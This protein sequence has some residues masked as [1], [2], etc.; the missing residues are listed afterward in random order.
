MRKLVLTN[1]VL[2]LALVAVAAAIM[3]ADPWL[4][5]EPIVRNVLVPLSIP[6]IYTLASEVSDRAL[7]RP[8][9]PL[10]NIFSSDGKEWDPAKLR[11]KAAVKP[12]PKPKLAPK[13]Q[14]EPKPTAEPSITGLL[15][16]P[17]VSA[18]LTPGGFVMEGGEVDGY[19]LR[20]IDGN[21]LAILSGPKG[22][23]ALQAKPRGSP[24]IIEQIRRAIQPI[25]P[26]QR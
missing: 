21:G 10:R 1:R 14:A 5:P 16:L 23:I 15:R 8:T 7:P 6:P 17:N 20:S 18:A 26:P 13:E 2:W 12:K 4:Q 19:Q 25:T 22:D 9:R 11:A 3:A 24:E